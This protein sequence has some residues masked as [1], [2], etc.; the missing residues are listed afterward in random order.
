M[1]R[2]IIN[3]ALSWSALQSTFK[4]LNLPYLQKWSIFG[5]I[6]GVIAGASAVGVSL[7]TT[8]ST[9]VFLGAGAG[10]VPPLPG[11]G[12]QESNAYQPSAIAGQAFAE[13]PWMFPV[14]AGLG[15]LAVGLLFYKIQPR[16]EGHGTDAVIDAF[17]NRQGN[18]RARVPFLT[19][20]ASP[21]TVG[22]GGSGGLEG[23][24]SQIGAG[25]SSILSKIFRF[26]ADDRRIAVAAGLAAGVGSIFKVPLGA[27]LFGT[28]VFYRQDFEVKALVPSV[29][30]SVAGYTVVGFVLGWA[31]VFSIPSGAA[32][33]SHPESL[34]LY[35]IIGIISATAS[36]AYVRT[37]NFVSRAFAGM[38]RV[39]AYAKPA[40]GG[41]AV[42]G[43]AMVAPQVLGNSYGW[44]QLAMLGSPLMMPIWLILGIAVLKIVATSL[45]IGS[46][47]SAGVFAPT[48]AIGGLLGAF[49][50]GL[51]HMLGLFMWV[52][53]SA[54][55]IVGMVAFFCA[56]A[57]TPIA[58]IVMGSE[59]TGGY[60]LLAPMMIA[61]VVAYAAS[62]LS[63]SIFKSQVATRRESPVHS[64][65]YYNDDDGGGISALKGMKAG[66]AASPQFITVETSGVTAA[67][68]LKAMRASGADVAFLFISKEKGGAG[69]QGAGDEEEEREEKAG[70]IVVVAATLHDMQAASDA[71]VPALAAA[72][73]N[74]NSRATPIVNDTDPLYDAFDLLASTGAPAIAVSRQGSIVGKISYEDIA[75]AYSRK[76]HSKK[77]P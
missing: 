71:G 38:K 37:F 47:G 53:V 4:F 5:I 64:A 16:G 65:E 50:G 22:S 11:E 54:A 72:T 23:P 6:I 31:P 40:I 10:F 35:G 15:G 52:D 28:E 63:A 69:A 74:G 19:A 76:I 67:E 18:I 60:G 29:I 43:V 55:A 42:G 48:M 20:I 77:N 45:T 41:V 26:D 62:S 56:T 46:G 32:R 57:K 73:D 58:T 75:R 44:L 68:V 14:V 1:R 36:M 59:L 24:M 61:T 13:R 51:F 12:Q 66:D 2:T 70:A 21:I 33:Y 27:A 34:L 30:A 8:I 39:P 17:H 25:L 3:S 7:L 49:V 9:S